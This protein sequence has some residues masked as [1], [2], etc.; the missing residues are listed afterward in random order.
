M[1]IY[2]FDAT[3]IAGESV[4]MDVY[5][6]QVLLVVNVASKC[7]FT[8]QYEGL[9]ALYRKYKD[10]GLSVLGFPC[11]QFGHQEPGSA[12]E[13][14]E[15]CTLNYGVSFPM[16]RKVEV[17]GPQAD[18]LFVHLR[19]QAPGHIT[20]EQI[21]SNRLY[22]YLAKNDP[23]ALKGDSIKWNFT[24]FLID[25]DGKVVGRYDSTVAPQELEEPIEDLLG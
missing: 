9:E 3:T 16:F 18:P 6:G 11:D 2:D 23:E 17:N 15:F 22:Q 14:Q 7:G 19:G 21:R 8:P 10:R 20:D 4:S 12:E 25:R 5:R 24:K 13:I 1:S